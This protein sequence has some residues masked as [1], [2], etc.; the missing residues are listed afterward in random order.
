MADIINEVKTDVSTVVTDVT[1]VEKPVVADITVVATDTKSVYEKISAWILA[2]P[3]SIY[4]I[5]GLVVGFL[6]RSLI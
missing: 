5:V 1:N 2:H 6:V 4:G 3:K